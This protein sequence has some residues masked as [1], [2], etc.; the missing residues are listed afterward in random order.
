LTVRETRPLKPSVIDKLIG[1]L[2]RTKGDGSR[3]I[4][5]C[6]IA[7]L[8]R[9]NETELRNCVIR[10][11]AW[12]L[13]DIHFAAAV[14]L[15]DYPEVRTSVL[16]LGVPDLTSMTINRG[17]FEQ[18]ARDLTDAIRN[19]EPRLVTDSV[20]VSFAQA[21]ADDENKLRFVIQ[22]ELKGAL[23][24]RYVEFKTSVALE[25]GEVVVSS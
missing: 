1:G 14:P 11:V 10:D 2:G 19:Y 4:A 7:S 8:D 6:F 15:D 5:P 3:D 16:N 23:D 17:I 9:F 21:V 12:I 22:G 20:I 18:R 25:T 24:D 13:N